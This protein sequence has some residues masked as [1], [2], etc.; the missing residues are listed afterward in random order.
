MAS[1]VRVKIV[2]IAFEL[3]LHRADGDAKDALAA[4]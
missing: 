1:L 3:V 4:A 2:Q